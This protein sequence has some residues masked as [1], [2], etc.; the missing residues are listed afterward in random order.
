LDLLFIDN[1]RGFS[2]LRAT[3]SGKNVPEDVKSRLL[4]VHEDNVSLKEQLKA[5]QEKLV[6]A[7]AVRVLR[8][9]HPRL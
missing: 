1:F 6:K 3:F 5:A 4:A 7:R 2:D 8:F 9:P